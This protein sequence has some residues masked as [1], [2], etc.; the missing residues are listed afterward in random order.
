MYFLFKNYYIEALLTTASGSRSFK[1]A[2]V[3]LSTGTQLSSQEWAGHCA[4]RS[5]CS[6]EKWGA[7]VNKLTSHVELRWDSFYYMRALRMHFTDFSNWEHNWLRAPTA[8][9]KIHLHRAELPNANDCGRPS[10]ENKGLL[11][12]PIYA[13]RL[14]SIPFNTI[15]MWMIVWSAWPN[16]PSMSHTQGSLAAWSYHSFLQLPLHI[17]SLSL[18]SFSCENLCSFNSILVSA[19]ERT[20]STLENPYYLCSAKSVYSTP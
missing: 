11:C 2:K 10:L 19:S 13:Q 6:T 3:P 4:E 14:S 17:L 5:V 7:L 1:E 12:W 9:S 8:V 18:K 20:L 16:L 15:F